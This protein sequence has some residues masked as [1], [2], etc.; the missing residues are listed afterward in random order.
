[1]DWTLWNDT[2]FYELC[3]VTPLLETAAQTRAQILWMLC[4]A[5][6]NK[7]NRPGQF[8]LMKDIWSRDSHANWKII[9]FQLNCQLQE[10]WKN[11]CAHKERGFTYMN[12]ASTSLDIG[13]TKTLFPSLF[14]WLPN[15]WPTHKICF[16]INI[17]HWNSIFSKRLIWENKTVTVHPHMESSTF[18]CQLKVLIH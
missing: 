15:L 5:T 1:M 11:N 8:S 3:N 17:G 6:K 16:L 13:N 4:E 7:K 14:L 12:P 2:T 9:C 10:P 18:I